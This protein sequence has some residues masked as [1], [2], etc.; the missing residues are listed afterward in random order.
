[1]NLLPTLPRYEN[2]S[3]PGVRLPEIEIENRY[4]KDLSIDSDIPNTDFLSKLCE[5]NLRDKGLD[6]V[7]NAQVYRDRLRMELDVLSDLGFVDYILLNWDIINFC[8]VNDIPTGPGR[9]SAAGSL[10]LFLIDVTKVDPVKYDLFFERFVSKS[11]AKKTEKEGVTYLDGS[12]LADVDN[13]NFL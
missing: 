9:G 4:Y 3:P 2:V 7:E 12:L 5:K 1:M 13:D 8:H 11:R 10:V 6:E